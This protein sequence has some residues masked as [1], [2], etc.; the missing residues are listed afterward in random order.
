LT[1]SSRL[2]REPTETY[3]GGRIRSLDGLR[4]IAI[5]LVMLYHL[6]RDYRPDSTASSI[7]HNF[8]GGGWLGVDVF[9][10]L[11]GFLITGIL[12]DSKERP[13]Y[14]RNFYARRVLRIF[15]LYYM[16]VALLVVA[17]AIYAQGPLGEQLHAATNQQWWLWTYLLNWKQASADLFSAAGTLT[18]H[19]WSLAV[20]E[21]FYLF[22]PLVMWLVPRKHIRTA[23]IMFIIGSLGL[24][25]G[26]LSS[27]VNWKV[28]Y[29]M[30]V[31]RLDGLA[32]GAWLAAALRDGVEL[33]RSAR[34]AAFMGAL[35]LFLV[36]ANDG[37]VDQ[38]KG[39]IIGVGL[40]AV[41]I[42]T[43]GTIWWALTRHR[44]PFLAHPFLVTFGKYSYGLYVI[45]LPV[46]EILDLQFGLTVRELQP[47]FGSALTA[48]LAMCLLGGI[49]SFILAYGSWHLF[50]ARILSL[51][52]FF[53]RE[54]PP[55]LPVGE[56]R[57]VAV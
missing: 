2:D 50:E 35:V 9:F 53:P 15:P 23:C 30:T 51:K 19:F 22:W 32:V 54:E 31:T 8:V 26:L 6:G 17:G 38:K 55:A 16:V 47:Y 13:R 39:I 28:P 34:I 18:V 44:E 12:L 7:W 37:G 52:R 24:R 48:S 21:Q 56:V 10:V 14:F 20:E 42:L 4:G 1:A 27:G 40:T 33:R 41:A 5:L 45:H 46:R 43:A 3:S 49:I 25:I 36:I 57:P 11:S 29:L